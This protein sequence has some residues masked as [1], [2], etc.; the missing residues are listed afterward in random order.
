M[1]K[2]VKISSLKDKSSDFSYWITKTDQERLDAIELL[3]E[4]YIKFKKDVQSRLQR[5]CSVVNKTQG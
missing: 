4:Q 3:R 2:V 1:D 5:V